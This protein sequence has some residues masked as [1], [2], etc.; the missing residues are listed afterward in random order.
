MTDYLFVYH[1]AT[2]TFI[3]RFR[4]D[5]DAQDGDAGQIEAAELESALAAL[6]KRFPSP[7]YVVECMSGTSW[8]AVETNFWGLY[9]D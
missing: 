3:T 9:R 7:D 1:P 8:E 6:R 5:E 2:R 4:V